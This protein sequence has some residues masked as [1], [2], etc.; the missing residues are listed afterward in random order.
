VLVGAYVA[1]AFLWRRIMRDLDV[2]EIGKTAT[3]RLYFLASLGR[4]LPGKVW[5]LAGLALLSRRAGL[6][7]ARATACALIGQFVF[8]TTGLL[9]LA[10]L[11]P[12]WRG[13]LPALVG[14][15]VLLAMAGGLAMLVATGY[16]RQIRERLRKRL[17]SRNAERLVNAFDLADRIR[18]RDAIS[19]FVAYGITWIAIGLAFSVFVDAFVPGTLHEIRHLSGTMAA[20]YL[21][22]YMTLV[23]AGLG[24]RESAM[25]LLLAEVPAIPAAAALVIAVLARVWFTL[26]EV[27]P[28]AAPPVL[29][30]P[31]AVPPVDASEV[32]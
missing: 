4:Y 21:V 8:L 11:L 19:W 20:S 9:F 32:S 31:D 7:A 23:P 26:A 29:R 12:E 1:H 10:M 5:G 25:F 28:L 3:V 16:G 24:V 14:A 17:T 2:G 15:A 27:L 13:G 18:V 6:P 22:G 30:T